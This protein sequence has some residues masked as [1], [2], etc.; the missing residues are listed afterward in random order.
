MSSFLFINWHVIK[1]CFPSPVICLPSDTVHAEK[2]GFFCFIYLVSKIMNWFS[3]ILR[4][5]WIS[6]LKRFN[7][8]MDP[9]MDPLWF[10][11]LLRLKFSHP[12]QVG[13]SSGGFLHPLR[14]TEASGQWR[15][16]NFSFAAFQIFSLSLGPISWVIMCSSVDLLEFI[17]LGCMSFIKFGTFSAIIL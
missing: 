7:L 13:T 1:R 12:W 9:W 16:T 6:F 10:W 14:L 17:R 11:S 3:F 8:L 5:W 4:R 15:V 2:A